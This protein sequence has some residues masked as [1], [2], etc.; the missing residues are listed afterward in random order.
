MAL[1]PEFDPSPWQTF[2]VRVAFLRLLFPNSST[3]RLSPTIK[4]RYAE[5]PECKQERQQKDNY[6]NTFTN[7]A[8]DA[9]VEAISETALDAVLEAA[10]DT[11]LDAALDAV[12]D[13]ILGTIL[14]VGLGTILE[15]GLEAAL[16]GGVTSTTSLLQRVYTESKSQTVSTCRKQ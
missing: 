9:R 16:K 3:T 2:L 13:A 11:V 6:F 15:V 5:K 12:L 4:G 8:E 1:S 14:V 10:L 7:D